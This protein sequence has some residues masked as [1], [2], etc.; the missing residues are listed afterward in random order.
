MAIKKK[1]RIIETKAYGKAEKDKPIFS[2]DIPISCRY[3]RSI[4]SRSTIYFMGRFKV[5]TKDELAQIARLHR[6]PDASNFTD[7]TGML[8]V[9]DLNRTN[10]ITIDKARKKGI[11]ILTEEEF[12]FLIST[13]KKNMKVTYEKA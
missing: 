2:G 7:K 4:Y 3:I 5:G 12:L 1:E 13:N 8:V 9:D 11:T 10:S 6:F